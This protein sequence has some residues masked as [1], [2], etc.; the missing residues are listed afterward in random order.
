M[1]GEDTC[2]ASGNILISS[3]SEAKLVVCNGRKLVVEPEWMG[4]RHSLKQKSKIDCYDRCSA[5]DSI[6]ECACNIGCS[7]HNLVWVKLGRKTKKGKQVIRRWRSNRFGD[8]EWV[9]I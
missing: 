2:K 4:V 8:D 9:T 1:V 6:R 3:L 7:D 5:N